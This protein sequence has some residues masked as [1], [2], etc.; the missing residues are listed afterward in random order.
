M[1][2]YVTFWNIIISVMLEVR[3]VVSCPPGWWGDW[4]QEG[5]RELSGVLEAF[6]ILINVSI[7]QVF[8]S[9]KTL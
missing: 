1:S 4:L 7:T 2:T 6:S 3:S 8:L 9:V 5:R